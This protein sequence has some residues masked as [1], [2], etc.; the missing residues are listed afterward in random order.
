MKVIKT[1][2]TN[3][4]V[5][6]FEVDQP[7]PGKITLPKYFKFKNENYTRRNYIVNMDEREFDQDIIDLAPHSL[8]KDWYASC[9]D[10]FQNKLNSHINKF[11]RITP[12]DLE[13]YITEF[14]LIFSSI[15]NEINQPISEEIQHNLFKNILFRFSELLNI[16]VELNI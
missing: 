9:Y 6:N 10:Q 7:V 12:A 11:K 2:K 8:N 5:V 16:P 4:L 14:V 13:C 3:G 15:G 1:F